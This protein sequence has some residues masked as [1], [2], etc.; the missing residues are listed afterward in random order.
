MP[1]QAGV[2]AVF[3]RVGVGGR[4]SALAPRRLVPSLP[5]RTAS[6]VP[7]GLRSFDQEDA[8][9]YLELL[10]GPRD[11]T[12]LPETIRFWKTRLEQ[13]DADRTFAVG[14]IY[15][16]SGCGKSSFVKAGLLPRLAANVIPVYVEAM[17]DDTVLRL[18]KQLR[19]V[20][21]E[22]D[23]DASL[24]ELL[25]F[26]REGRWLPR[27]KKVLIVLDQ[28]EQWL[29]AQGGG[30]DAQLV[31]AIRQCDG[32]RVQCLLLVRDDFWSAT[33]RFMQELEIRPVDGE[34]LA[35]VDRFDLLH[36]RRVL[37]A[38]GRA[39]GRLPPNRRI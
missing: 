11:R 18:L 27:G 32:S 13:T 1:R 12:G 33:S 4:S 7:R 23:P 17:A 26:L 20:C 30:H 25:G 35:F 19:K 6:I 36:A 37:A 22:S 8:E 24:P 29:H 2:R 15:G 3:Q 21:P 9:S 39:Y 31:Q 14:M 5:P 16:P 38:L 28:F 34:N 10:P